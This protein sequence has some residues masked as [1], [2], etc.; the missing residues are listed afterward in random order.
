VALIVTTDGSTS[1]ATD[2]TSHEAGLFAPDVPAGVV[3]D[4]LDELDE[5]T[6]QPPARAAMAVQSSTR[7]TALENPDRRLSR[8]IPGLIVPSRAASRHPLGMTG[9]PQAGL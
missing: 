7:N 5:L 9:A 4:A 6:E 1:F 2:S 3:D 8:R